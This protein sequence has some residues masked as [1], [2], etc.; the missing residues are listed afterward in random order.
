MNETND[1]SILVVDDCST[2]RWTLINILK[3]AG[4]T[5]V[6]EAVD[7]QTALE[8]LKTRHIDLAISDW[9]MP[10][11]DGLELLKRI[12]LDRALSHIPVLMLTSE[13]AKPQI[14]EAIKSGANGYLFKPF[15]ADVIISKV[16][17]FALAKEKELNGSSV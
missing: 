17:K 6:H 3:N 12:R 7:G 1:L 8:L 5:Q 2:M 15:Q 4:Y 9:K 10:N 14:I 13:N 16:E 11:M